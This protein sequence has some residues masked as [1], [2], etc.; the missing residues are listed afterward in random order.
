[1]LHSHCN[2]AHDAF[3]PLGGKRQGNEAKAWLDKMYEYSEHSQASPNE[4]LE[5]IMDWNK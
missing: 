3:F 1:M 2:C 5:S 4:V